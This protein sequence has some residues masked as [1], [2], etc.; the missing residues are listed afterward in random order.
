MNKT[1]RILST[2]IIVLT[3]L[4]LS[5]Q[6]AHAQFWKKKSTRDKVE[7]AKQA[8]QNVTSSQSTATQGARRQPTKDLSGYMHYIVDEKGDTVYVAE[9]SPVWVYP[10]GTKRSPD[11]RKYYKLVYNFNKVYP[12]AL[13]AKKLLATVDINTEEMNKFGREKYINMKQKELLKEFEP[14]VRKMTISQG[15]LLCR[16]LDREIG[17]TSY[18]IIK[19]YKNGLAAGFWQGVGKLFDQNLK[20]HYDPQGVDKATEELVKKWEDGEFDKLYYSIFWEEPKHVVI[21][22]KYR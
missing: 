20:S 14:V 4:A 11:W 8:Q 19:D 12:Y 21:P 15:Q 16:L 3:G 22:A 7:Q 1:L 6:D 2:L 13:M 5:Q 9:L 10:R 18:E 17:M